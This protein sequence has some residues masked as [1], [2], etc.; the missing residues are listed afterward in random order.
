M[1]HPRAPS[2]GSSASATFDDGQSPVR[3]ARGMASRSL[4]YTPVPM[5]KRS[6]AHGMS[7]SSESGVWPNW[8]LKRFDGF[9]LRLVTLSRTSTTSCS[10]VSP[11]MR[12]RPNS[13]PSTF[14]LV[15]LSR[16]GLTSLVLIG[17]PHFQ[18][19]NRDARRSS[20]S[21]MRLSLPRRRRT[22]RAS[23]SGP[24]RGDHGRLRGRD[25]EKPTASAGSRIPARTKGIDH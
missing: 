10:Y 17:A 1:R 19:S 2:R 8:S 11:S 14:A 21:R 25:R 6:H 16:V 15:R 22:L 7:S 9:F 23:S 18:R 20:C 13:N 5:I 12:M 3:F 24:G 4:P